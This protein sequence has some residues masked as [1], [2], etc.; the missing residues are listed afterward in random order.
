VTHSL[1]EYE[2]LAVRL[3]LQPE[4]LRAYRDRLAENRLIQPLFDTDRFRR[5][6]EAAYRH[7]WQLWQK[8]EKPK[9]F[10]IAGV[11]DD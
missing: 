3:A 10:A 2:A 9:S 1:E 11:G 8:G 7:M 5:H 4:L 6:L